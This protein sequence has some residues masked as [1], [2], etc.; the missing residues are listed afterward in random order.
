ML[1]WVVVVDVGGGDGEDGAPG[2]Y[3]GE[4]GEEGAPGCDGGDGEEGVP[5]CDGEED[6]EDE[7]DGA[8]M[9]EEGSGEGGQGY[10]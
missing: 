3:G 7:E 4:D 10:Q 6:G 5:G 2:C 8:V 1:V 9:R